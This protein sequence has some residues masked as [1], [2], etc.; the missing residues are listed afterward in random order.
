MR[1]SRQPSNEASAHLYDQRG[2]DSEIDAD[3]LGTG[4]VREKSYQSMNLGSGVVFSQPRRKQQE[5]VV[6]RRRIDCDGYDA[7][8]TNGAA[9]AYDLRGR[10]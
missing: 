6:F 3:G 7:A 1:T 10:D 8:A 9:D 2:A 4:K 5:I